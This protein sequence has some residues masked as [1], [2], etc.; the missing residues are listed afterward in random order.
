MRRRSLRQLIELAAIC[1][2]EVVELT[3]VFGERWLS[4][5]PPGGAVWRCRPGA[6]A[7]A[8][9]YAWLYGYAAGQDGALS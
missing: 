8:E 3:N 9:A 6:S 5:V 1:D 7:L 4:L 2:I